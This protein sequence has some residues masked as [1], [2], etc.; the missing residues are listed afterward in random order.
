MEIYVKNVFRFQYVVYDK[1]V[2]ETQ[3]KKKIWKSVF[4][5]RFYHI[6][7]FCPYHRFKKQLMTR[8]GHAQNI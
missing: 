1:I 7:R 3:E 2:T 5:L 6:H 4:Q 8:K